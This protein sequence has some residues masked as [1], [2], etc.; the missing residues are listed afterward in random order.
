MRNVV[1][2]GHLPPK[3]GPG[4]AQC[5]EHSLA[6]TPFRR[7]K[8][9]EVAKYIQRVRLGCPISRAQVEPKLEPIDHV[10]LKLGQI[11]PDGP[12]IEAVLCACRFKS[13]PAANIC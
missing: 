7:Q 8:T 6:R 1:L 3:V 10:D 11:D 9:L 13:G 4:Q 5:G 2:G 12:Q